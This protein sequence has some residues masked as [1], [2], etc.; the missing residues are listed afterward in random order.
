MRAVALQSPCKSVSL[1]CSA[2]VGAPTQQKQSLCNSN[3]GELAESHCP[4]VDARAATRQREAASVGMRRKSLCWSLGSSNH[5]AGI[6]QAA[7][8]KGRVPHERVTMSH[9]ISTSPRWGFQGRAQGSHVGLPCS[10]FAPPPAVHAACT[11]LC[12][13]CGRRQWDGLDSHAGEPCCCHVGWT[14][15][16]RPCCTASK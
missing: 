16:C 2:E 8:Q 6:R 3:N 9:G 5:S 10:W 7:N 11:M 4:R 1:R 13:G 15:S 12:S 14:R